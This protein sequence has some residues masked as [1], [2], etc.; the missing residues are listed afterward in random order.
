MIY[1][2]IL[3]KKVIISAIVVILCSIVAFN[4]ERITGS[5]V[6]SA[7]SVISLS[8]DGVNFIDNPRYNDLVI[9]AGDMIYVKLVPASNNKR[10]F[11]YD[12]RHSSKASTFETKCLDR[13]GS[14]CVSSLAVYK[15]PVDLWVDGTYTIKIAGVSGKAEFAFE[16]PRG[17]I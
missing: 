6:F 16:N 3:N 17:G 13:I 10:V 12:P 15:T 2:N 14:R 7:K 4:F 9:S 5:A 8:R 1:T 11:I